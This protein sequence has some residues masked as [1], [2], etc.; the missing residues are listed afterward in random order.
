MQ[1]VFVAGAQCQGC[2]VGLDGA[3]VV[4]ALVAGVAQ[5]VEGVRL[6]LLAFDAFEGLTGIRVTAGPVERD[7]TTVGIS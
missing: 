6:D 7:T 5:V 2:L 3:L 4:T 1:G